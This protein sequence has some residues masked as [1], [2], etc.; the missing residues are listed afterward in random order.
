MNTLGAVLVALSGVMAGLYG[1][2]ALRQQARRARELVRM[3][4]LML[5]ELE[6]FC[7]PLPSLFAS[8]AE[9]TDGAAAVLCSRAALAMRAEDARF[10]DAWAFACDTLSPAEREVLGPLGEILGRYGA[11]EQI[12]ALEASLAEARRYSGRLGAS[13][14]ERCR[15]RIGLSAACGLLAAVLLW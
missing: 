1:A 9:R 8:L 2:G 15:L 6:R 7:P 14:G 3:L 10:R 4:E 11:Q 12:S 13:L 5:C